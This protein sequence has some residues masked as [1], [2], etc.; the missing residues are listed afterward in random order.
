MS[1]ISIMS[2]PSLDRAE[3]HYSDDAVGKSNENREEHGN[4][5]WVKFTKKI[6]KKSNWGLRSRL[7]MEMKAR[8]MIFPTHYFTLLSEKVEIVLIL[9]QK[10]IESRFLEKFWRI[11]FL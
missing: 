5:T 9:S 2:S 7:S 10:V 4:C 3:N 6:A 8:R 1:F 11:W